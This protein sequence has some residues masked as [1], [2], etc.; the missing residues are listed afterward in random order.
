MLEGPMERSLRSLKQSHHFHL[1]LLPY[2]KENF[3][4]CVGKNHTFVATRNKPVCGCIGP[5]FIQ[6]AKRN[7][8]CA[9]VHAGNSPDK[10]RQTMLA[11]G[12]YHCRDI[13]EWQGGS[14]SA[15][16]H[17]LNVAVKSVRQTLMDFMQN[18]NVPVRN[19]TQ[20]TSCDV[21]F[22]C[23]HMKSNAVKQPKMLRRS[24]TQTWEKGTQISLSQH[25][26]F[27]LNS[28]PRTLTCTWTITMLQ[29][30]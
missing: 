30:T 13:H 20:L 1:L 15:F 25:L 26:V 11:L 12:K 10:H 19:I 22:M 3:L 24:S 14:C 23:W 5:G 17:S 6:N 21:N 18:S 4:P 9:L 8:Y 29:Q 7:H 2:T 27:S 28:A 16:I